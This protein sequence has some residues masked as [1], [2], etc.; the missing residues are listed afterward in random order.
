MGIME[1][2]KPIR[3]SAAFMVPSTPQYICDYFSSSFRTL[4]SS[5]VSVTFEIPMELFQ[6]FYA[7]IAPSAS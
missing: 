2:L 6:F 5:A 4:S 3:C 7:K 1:S